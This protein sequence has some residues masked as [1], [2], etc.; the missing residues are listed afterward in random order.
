MNRAGVPVA[1]AGLLAVVLAAAP[2]VAAPRADSALPPR[3]SAV[4]APGQGCVKPSTGSA[5]VASAAH[6]VLTPARSWPLSRGAGVRVAVLDTGLSGGVSPQLDGQV[7]RGPDVVRGGRTRSDCIGHGT[8]VAGLIAARPRPGTTVVGMAPQAHV[9]A[10]TVTAARGA[11]GPDVLAKGIRAAVDAGCRIIDVSVVAPASSRRLV[12]AVEYAIARGALVIAPAV[13]DDQSLDGPVYPA[14][15]P[16]VVSV[17]N[18]AAQG[19]STA[20]L[21][22]PGDAVLSVGPGAGAFVG[23]G[24]AYASALVAATAALMDAYRPGLTLEQRVNRLISTAYPSAASA[25]VVDPEAAVSMILPGEYGAA[26]ERPRPGPGVAALPAPVL[27][28]VW[29]SS[30]AVAGAGALAVLLAL[31]GVLTVRRGRERGWHP[32]R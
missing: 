5:V 2:A 25:P 17:A 26:P 14:A 15:L 22:A 12:A 27:D 20:D 3:I 19:T 13:A 8:F 23:S 24:A 1:G 28:P 11:T 29:Y 6:R 31:A 9:Y 32:E 16:G 10:V 30:L 4:L 7:T 21:A 18:S